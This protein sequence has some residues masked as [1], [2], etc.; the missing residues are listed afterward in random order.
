MKIKL[1][2]FLAIFFSLI[3]CEK[4]KFIVLIEQPTEKE[5]DNINLKLVLNNDKKD[6]FATKLKYSYITPRFVSNEFLINEKNWHNLAVYIQDK[7]F[8]YKLSYP[9][10]KYIIISPFYDN[11]NISIGIIK[12]SKKFNLH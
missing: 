7:K 1:I 9:N 6:A 3:S 8:N 4:R 10:D 5:L 11:K 12:K 2:M